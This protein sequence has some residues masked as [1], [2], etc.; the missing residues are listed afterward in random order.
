[1]NEDIKN[2]FL[3]EL[4]ELKKLNI[5]ADSYAVFGSGPLAIRGIREARDIELI[6][7]YF[8]KT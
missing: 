5:P 3:K 4:E 7:E 6:K 1:M 8:Q 2:N